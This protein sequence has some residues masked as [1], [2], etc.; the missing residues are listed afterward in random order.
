MTYLS[1]LVNRQEQCSRINGILIHGVKKN[2]NEHTDEVVLKKMKM[3]I[4]LEVSQGDI[5][6]THRIGVWGRVKADP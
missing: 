1:P 5:Y 6:C 3:E 2:Q 4:D